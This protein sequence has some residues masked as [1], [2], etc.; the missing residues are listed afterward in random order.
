MSSSTY[1]GTTMP[2]T[3]QY[4]VAITDFRHP[5]YGL[6]GTVDSHLTDGRLHVSVKDDDGTFRGI[7]TLRVNQVQIITRSILPRKGRRVQFIH[8][9]AREVDNVL[10]DLP[11]V[12]VGTV[13]GTLPGSKD[14]TYY[15]IESEGRTFAKLRCDLVQYVN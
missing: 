3:E 5:L 13:L 12:K 8:T 1:I 11:P 6:E 10:V 9:S 14:G 4:Q 15:L 7:H 2:T